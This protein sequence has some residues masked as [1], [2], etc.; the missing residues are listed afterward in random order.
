MGNVGCILVTFFLSKFCTLSHTFFGANLHFG[1]PDSGGGGTGINFTLILGLFPGGAKLR[2]SQFSFFLVF[3]HFFIG[4]WVVKFVFSGLG[5]LLLIVA[6]IFV[7]FSCREGMGA[8]FS[9]IFPG[10]YFQGG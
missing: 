9:S 10:G 5:T 6:S 3:T 7:D 2:A 8:G 4:G 1:F